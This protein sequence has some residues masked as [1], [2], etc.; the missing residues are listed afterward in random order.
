M[1]VFWL[2]LL[3]F[4]NLYFSAAMA[5]TYTGKVVS[6]KDKQPLDATSIVLLGQ[7]NSP[8]SYT[9]DSP[10]GSFSLSVPSGQHAIEIAFSIIG[11]ARQVIPLNKYK[12][13]QT[14][15][16]EPQVFQIKEVKVTTHRITQSHDTLT[17]SV[18]GFRQKQD[19]TIA[20]VIAKMPGL[21]V[22]AAGGIS[23]QGKR[24]NKFY[25]EGMDL[26]GSQ[27]AQA[28]ENIKAD[29]VKSVQV[30]ENHQPV[31]ALRDIKFSDQAAL[32][33][34]LK[35]EAKNI[36]NGAADIGMGATLQNSTDWLRDCR[37]IGMMF[38]SRKQSISMYK[39]NNSGK[40][41]QREVQD[42]ASVL[43]SLKEETGILSPISLS[44]PELQESRYSFN[45]THL[46]ATN[47]LFKTPK[48]NDL[49]IQFNALID[50]SKQNQ[51]K[52]T[53]Y[54]DVKD[55]STLKENLSAESKRSEWKGEMA[56]NINKDQIYLKNLMR[57]Y[58]DF[59]KSDG[60]TILNG[61]SISQ[62]ITPRKKYL[63]DDLELIRSFKNET[64]LSFSSQANYSY[65]PGRLLL[66][67]GTQE[68]LNIHTLS[69]DAYT[70]FRHR[71][72][73]M[74][75]TYKGGI[76]TKSQNMQVYNNEASKD[77]KYR[78]Y[79]G[80]VTPSINVR[81]NGFN[82]EASSQV[83]W[84]YRSYMDNKKQ[85]ALIE[86]S[87]AMNYDISGKINISTGYMYSWTPADL[88]SICNTPIYTSYIMVTTNSGELEKTMTHILY[89]SF[90]Y[91][92][93]MKGLFMNCNF[94]YSNKKNAQLYE[95]T[96]VDNIY[97]R[98]ATDK[99]TNDES[100]MITGRIGKATG[101]ARLCV[102]LE[103][104][105]SLDNYKLLFNE[106]QTPY[107][108]TGEDIKFNISFRPANFL[109]IEENSSYEYSKQTNKL[110]HSLSTSPLR[111]F[112][113]SLKTF[114]FPSEGWQIEWDNE[115]YHSN[116]KSVS[117][118]FFSDMSLSY[119]TKVYEIRLG[120]NNILGNK[121][122]ERT[123]ITAY[124]QVYTIS[125]LRPREILGIVSFNF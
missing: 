104:R 10:Q 19:R 110:D 29:K 60:T 47:W 49:R 21:E 101:W 12:N 28:S 64:S 17:Y 78:E 36:W 1:K 24:I 27:Y 8:V 120:C 82:L 106:I 84:L 85:N 57:G 63:S 54:T 111:S 109:S 46:F 81:R 90:K 112:Y 33:I 53:Y 122:Y 107:Q 70:F 13:G 34:V 95:S 74:Y 105:Y 43:S 79:R 31:K 32:N 91:N 38:G 16:M 108:M 20:D 98:K 96:L 114:L 30:L 44:A 86:P 45:D 4:I 41:L 76:S 115:C 118:N 35:E 14:V 22:D 39:C 69:W 40:D 48:K 77:D 3:S 94:D 71:I 117:F 116:D 125:R 61:E 72:A 59:N 73:G 58:A 68:I 51:Y 97:R 62:R 66:S 6:T 123:N 121:Q 65:L 9:Y 100:Y 89:S 26:L 67:D 50:K 88:K 99:H 75:I 23:F 103:G 37:L 102:S 42:L 2:I 80:Y 124:Q 93:P 55:A 11:Y 52:E 25:I 92:D 87:V 7:N 56:Y 119:R 113:H 18:G 15:F 83:S 5:Q